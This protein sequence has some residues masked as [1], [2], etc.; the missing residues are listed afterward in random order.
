MISKAFGQKKLPLHPSERMHAL[1]QRV[2]QN[3][4]TGKSILEKSLN[5]KRTQFVFADDILPLG[6]Y[7]P[8]LN[9]VSLN[10]HYSDEDLCSTLVHE[11]RHSLQGHIEGGNLK[12]RLLINRTQEADA[13]AFQCAAAFE[14]R[15]AYPKVWESFKRS[16]QKIASAYEKEA[17]KGRK[18]ALGEAFKAWFDDR[19]YVDRYDSDAVLGVMGRA[20]PDL[21]EVSETRIMKSVCSGSQEG[22]YVDSSF[23]KTDRA[24]TVKR[25]TAFRLRLAGLPIKDK[26]FYDF[27]IPKLCGN[28]VREIKKNSFAAKAAAF[29]APRDDGR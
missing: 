27:K 4:P 19:D 11:A 25:G 21:K 5:E 18:A 28:G 15:K 24:L 12:S 22:V 20:R 8:S 7:I 10:A 2:C 17:E 23:L 16:S 6:V 3:S 26:S 29:L 13:K 14:M 1:I 9:T